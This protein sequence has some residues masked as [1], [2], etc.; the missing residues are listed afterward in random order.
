MQK[1][2][3]A[4]LFF[5]GRK[6]LLMGMVVFIM[7]LYLWDNV[8]E[9]IIECVSNHLS[10]LSFIQRWT[11]ERAETEMNLIDSVVKSLRSLAKESRERYTLLE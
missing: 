11:N 1:S 2:T 9:T 8:A 3:L 7:T 5:I 6:G 4:S 10:N